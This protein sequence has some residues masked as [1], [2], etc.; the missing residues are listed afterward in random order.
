MSKGSGVA[1]QQ[2]N[3]YANRLRF[4]RG[5]IALQNNPAFNPRVG[6]TP[7]PPQALVTPGVQNYESAYSTI[8]DGRLVSGYRSIS[9]GGAQ[10]PAG[11]CCATTPPS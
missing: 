7:S 8:V 10:N 6:A 9:S 5:K 4:I 11:V 2:N 1:A 3:S